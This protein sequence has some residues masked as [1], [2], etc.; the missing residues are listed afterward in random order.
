MTMEDTLHKLLDMGFKVGSYTAIG[1]INRK[2]QEVHMSKEV[3]SNTSFD[4]STSRIVVERAKAGDCDTLIN[5]A[6]A[7]D[8][9]EVNK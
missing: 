4:T 2:F 7:E 9:F 6:K 8:F 5:G 1:C 3:W